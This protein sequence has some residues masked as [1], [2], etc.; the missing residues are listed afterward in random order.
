VS[1][2]LDAGVALS[3]SVHFDRP[4]W[5]ADRLNDGN[6]LWGSLTAYDASYVALAGRLCVS[7]LTADAAFTT[8]PGIRCLVEFVEL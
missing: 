1:V 7:L 6:A 8:A 5:A 2:V 4:A 3:C